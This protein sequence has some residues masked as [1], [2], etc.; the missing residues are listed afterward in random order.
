MPWQTYTSAALDK[1]FLLKE[2]PEGI[3]SLQFI[4]MFY[5][6]IISETFYS[7]VCDPIKQKFSL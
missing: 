2:L 5:L 6:L 7:I 1:H 3:I 4:P